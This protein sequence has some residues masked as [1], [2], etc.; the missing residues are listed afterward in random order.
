MRVRTVHP[1][2][3]VAEADHEPVVTLQSLM[4]VAAVLRDSG[5]PPDEIRAVVTTAEP[6]IVHRYVE[7]HLERLEEWLASQRRSLG[8]I[9]RLLASSG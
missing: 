7:L 1:T 3:R 4:L 8:A 6:E 2:A 9:E 5:M